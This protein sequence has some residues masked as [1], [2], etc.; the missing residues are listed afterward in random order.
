MKE[1]LAQAINTSG[2]ELS[3]LEDIE[4]FWENPQVELEAVFR[5]GICTFL[6]PTAFNDLEMGEQGPFEKP[7][8]L[9][10]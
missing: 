8:V 3:N 2:Y 9:D 7:I 4:L 5:P 6:S 10:E 1:A